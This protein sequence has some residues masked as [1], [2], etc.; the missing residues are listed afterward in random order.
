LDKD[1]FRKAERALYNYKTLIAEVEN[2][3]I[4]IEEEKKSIRDVQL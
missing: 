1:L 2:L 4:V 3:K